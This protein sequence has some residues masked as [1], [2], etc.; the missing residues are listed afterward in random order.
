AKC[1]PM[2]AKLLKGDLDELL[3]CPKRKA[4]AAFIGN[5]DPGLTLSIVPVH[6]EKLAPPHR[7]SVLKPDHEGE[8]R[9][10]KVRLF[11]RQ[12]VK[13]ALVREPGLNGGEVVGSDRC[14]F[15]LQSSSLLG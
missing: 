12:G 8:D 10:L 1:D 13:K 9:L 5:R 6:V 11:R 7:G 3:S 2:K 15:Q 4:G 14:E